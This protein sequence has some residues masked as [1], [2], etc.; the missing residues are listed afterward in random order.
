MPRLFEDVHGGVRH[1]SPPAYFFVAT[2]SHRRSRAASLIAASPAEQ[3]V[4]ILG[5]EV[6]EGP[7][8]TPTQVGWRPLEFGIEPEALDHQASDCFP[9]NP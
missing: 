8:Q 3:R 5:Q 7:S 2:L 4:F 9:I 6:Q 1:P